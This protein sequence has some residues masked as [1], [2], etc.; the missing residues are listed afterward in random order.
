MKFK[1]IYT[2]ISEKPLLD[3]IKISRKL[4]KDFFKEGLG[5]I[6]TLPKLKDI[7]KASNRIIQAVSS[8]EKMIIFGHDDLDGITSTF[9][10]YD[11]L[12]KIGSKNHYYH[13]PNRFTE[14]HGLQ[15]NF[16]E[17]VQNLNCSL[18]ITVDGGISSY[19]AVEK[20]NNFGCDVIITDHHLIPK[21]LP[22]TLAIVN[23]KQ[24]NCPF[25]FDQLAGVGVTYFLI[26]E[27]AKQLDIE[28][29]SNYIFWVAV[30]T[31]ADRVPLVNLNRN[32]VR[33][34]IK[35]WSKI[36]DETLD[37]FVK[38]YWKPDSLD[39]KYSLIRKIISVFNNGREKGGE[40]KALQ[41]LLAKD[42]Q[43]F[44]LLTDLAEQQIEQERV[45]KKTSEFIANIVPSELCSYYIY[46]DNNGEI[47]YNL[48]GYFA[49]QIS[50]K[51]L[52][53]T[54]FLKRKNGSIVC[55]ARCTE[56]FNLVESFNFCQDYLV[57]YGGHV[58]AAG[59]STKEEYLEGFIS[60]FK[61]YIQINEQ[62]IL[63]NKI[64]KVDAVL[65]F[66]DPLKK[67]WLK[68]VNLNDL[69]PFGENNQIP[70]VL[71]K[72]VEYPKD[73]D[74]LKLKQNGNIYQN[75]K[76]YNVVISMKQA[77]LTIIDYELNKT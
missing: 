21:K 24:I 72:N 2:D 39:S 38:K 30:G 17:R 43:K 70:N 68:D 29:P 41:V 10:L 61:E 46:F 20:I 26:V 42:K 73:F 77:E 3:Q 33:E 65:D 51:Y 45:L 49:S 1:W 64:I 54:V 47:P 66:F 5:N 6:H 59:F 28:I 56:G 71:I 60:K 48:L 36:D 44:K 75:N 7:E 52:I 23:S 31:I 25:L 35:V 22:K 19:D 13:I 67:K 32:I 76:L 15:D 40:H 74:E 53:P 11:F 9:I 55:E 57:Q 27:M 4:D 50:G 16:I 34:M 37:C 12:T 58:K 63:D 69:H 18:V 14:N 8:Q 62:A